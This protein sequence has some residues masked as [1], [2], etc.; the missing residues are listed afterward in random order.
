MKVEEV[1]DVLHA[2]VRDLVH[3]R[4]GRIDC[5]FHDVLV[6]GHAL[7]A[8]AHAEVVTVGELKRV[9]EQDVVTAAVHDQEADVLAGR[10]RLVEL[11]RD[12]TREAAVAMDVPPTA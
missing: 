8:G 2:R 9:T 7:R 4:R 12:Q 6:D 3:E 10:R 5:L 11:R 1:D